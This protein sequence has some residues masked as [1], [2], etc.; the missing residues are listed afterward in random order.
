MLDFFASAFGYLLNFLYNMVGNYGYAIIIFTILVKLIMLPISVK[1]Q[2]TMKK[3]AKVQVKLREL[4]EKYGNDQVRLG[5]ETMDLYKKEN[6]SPFSGC[7]GSIVQMILILSVFFLVSRPLTFM[8]NV[9]PTLIETYTKQVQEQDPNASRYPEIGIIKLMGDKDEKVKIN[10]DFLGLDLSDVPTQN[11]T[12]WKVYIIP[13]LYVITSIASTKLTT[14]MNNKRKAENEEKSEPVKT[15][16]VKPN[17]KDKDLQVTKTNDNQ[18]LDT[19][20]EVNR[21]MNIMMPLMSVSIALIAPLGLALYWF[22]SNLLMIVER[23]ILDKVCK[24][25]E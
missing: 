9:D 10:M 25:E 15:K 24:E 3:T 14:A 20:D 7:L 8:R 2:K 5:Q 17:D 16:E 13:G 12:D 6:M 11:Y 4:Q 22:V 19:M 1:Q 18:E 23:L 21:Q